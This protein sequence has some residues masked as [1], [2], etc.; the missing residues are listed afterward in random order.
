MP[1]LNAKRVEWGLSPD[2]KSL[3]M[4]TFL[5]DK[6]F[7]IYRSLGNVRHHCSL[8]S[9]KHDQCRYFQPLNL[10]ITGVA[11]TSLKDKFGNWYAKEVTSQLD[12][13]TDVYSVDMKLQLPVLKPIHTKWLISL[14][15]YLRNQPELIKKGFKQAGINDAIDLEL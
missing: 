5:R 1:Y 4:L 10:T 8:C 6:N 14:Y 13:G 2:Q 11:K 12:D 7:E 15:D 9:C 3:L